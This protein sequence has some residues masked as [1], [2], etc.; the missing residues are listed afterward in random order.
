MNRMRV[1]LTA[2]LI[3]LGTPCVAGVAQA[4]TS[5]ADDPACDPRHLVQGDYVGHPATLVWEEA[6]RVVRRVT[7]FFDDAGEAVSYSELMSSGRFD[8]VERRETYRFVHLDFEK[9]SAVVQLQ[10][11]EGRRF[12]GEPSLADVLSSPELGSPSEMI[13]RVRTTCTELAETH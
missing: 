3:A 13:R 11:P 5:P 4:T 8:G 1:C 6:G 10:T 2:A 9:G 12:E 7:V